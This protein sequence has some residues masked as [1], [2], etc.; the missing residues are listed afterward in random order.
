MTMPPRRSFVLLT[1]IVVLGAAL[2]SIAALLRFAGAESALARS[3]VDRTSSRAMVSSAIAVLLSE[4]DSQR[5]RILEG[6]GVRLESQ[7]ELFHDHATIAVLRLL[8]PT[9]SDSL[10]MPLGGL[11]DINTVSQDDLV[12]SGLFDQT[13]AIAI[14]SARDA[15]PNKRFQTLEELL[16]IRI[17]DGIAAIDP[18]LFYGPLVDFEPS[19]DA[20]LVERDRGDRVLEALG[21]R[22]PTTIGEVFT[23]YSFEPALQQSG[24]LRINLNRP[25]SEELGARLD[26]RFGQGTGEGVGR[27]MKQVQFTSDEVLVKVLRQF[28]VGHAQWAELLDVLSSEDDWHEGRVDLNQAPIEVLMGVG[29]DEDTAEAIVQA[30]SGLK[31]DERVT[32]TWPLARSLLDEDQFESLVGRLSTRTWIWGLRIVVGVV[33]I[34]D[35][36][37]PLEN[38][39]TI[40]LVVDLA[41]PRARLAAIRDISALETGVRLL[42]ERLIED[43]ESAE[44]AL[45]RRTSGEGEPET[46]SFFDDESFFDN[47]SFFDSGSLFDENESESFEAENAEEENNENES[48]ARTPR[49]T[50]RGP[51]GRWSP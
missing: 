35:P 40:D 46:E 25:W 44:R 18:E 39:I 21:V 2:I 4:L 16:T 51:H 8:P 30:R 29:I 9:P 48:Q 38:P 31:P 7:Y 23:V 24:K 42:E 32:R 1:V 6:N 20:G 34:E 26:E 50:S 17:E 36:E 12:A 5:A 33:S 3:H 28:N 49:Q 27:I 13:Q 10:L 37:A 14:L 45:R 22:G 41:A 15:K 47:E 19:R 11:L 43:A